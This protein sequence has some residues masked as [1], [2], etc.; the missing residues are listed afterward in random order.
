M[1][2]EQV[3]PPHYKRGD[4]EC[5]DIIETFGLN[6]HLGN[7]VKYVLRHKDKDGLQDLK[8]AAWYLAREIANRQG[9]P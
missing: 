2:D 1:T 6:F 5:I 4:I 9:R 7:V 3:N 8:K